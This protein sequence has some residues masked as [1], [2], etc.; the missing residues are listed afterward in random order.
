MLQAEKIHK[1]CKKTLKLEH[2]VSHFWAH[3]NLWAWKH[4][5]LD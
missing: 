5:S 4:I 2:G 1:I 3:P